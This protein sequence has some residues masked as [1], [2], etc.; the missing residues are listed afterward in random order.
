MIEKEIKLIL[1]NIII[2]QLEYVNLS[3]YIYYK[4][5]YKEDKYFNK[6]LSFNNVKNFNYSWEEGINNEEIDEYFYE[7]NIKSFTRFFHR[8]KE[9]KKIYILDGND[10]LIII[11]FNEEKKWKYR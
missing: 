9:K 7:Y 4:H 11:E 8:Y 1:E 10:S 2:D 3:L 6:I 5:Y